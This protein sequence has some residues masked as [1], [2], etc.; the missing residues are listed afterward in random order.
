[1]IYSERRI[2]FGFG[3]GLT[4]VVRNLLIIN[5]AVYLMQILGART[6]VLETLYTL[7]AL[8][9]RSVTHQLAL[10]QLGTYLFLHGNLFHIFFNMF[11]LWMF[12]CEVERALG[13]RRF[14]KFYFIAGIGAAVFHLL[15]SWN[16]PRPVIGASGAIYGVLVAFASLFPN[17][18]VTLLLFFVL[19]VNLKAKTLVAIFVGI[20]LISGIQ[21]QVFGLSD[22]T[23]HLAHLGGA[24]VGYLLIRRDSLIAGVA[25]TIGQRQQRRRNIANIRREQ[26]IRQKREEIDRILD[27]I[28]QVGYD[29]ITDEEKKSLREASEFLKRQ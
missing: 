3:G 13:S 5:I 8:R 22:G 28:N 29:G 16:S 25:R 19:P 24:L 23:A 7:F 14:L 17:R 21:G 10:W 26:N 6:G 4:P 2:Q 15:F 12:G 11:T 1:M 20:S 18:V 27:R 9:P